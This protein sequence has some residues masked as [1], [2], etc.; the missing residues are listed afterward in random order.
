MENRLVLPH[1]HEETY[2]PRVVDTGQFTELV[3]DTTR[4]NRNGGIGGGKGGGALVTGPF[5]FQ[6]SPK[7]EGKVK[8]LFTESI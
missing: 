7:K 2:F 5:P 8:L 6:P 1:S 4:G 3:Q